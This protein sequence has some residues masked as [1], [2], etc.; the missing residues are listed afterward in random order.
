MLISIKQ[1]VDAFSVPP[2][3]IRVNNTAAVM[4]TATL[5]AFAQPGQALDI[6]VS[7]MGNSKS[8]RRG[9]L[10]VAIGNPLGFES[11]VT[12]GVVSALGRSIRSVSGR[13]IEDVT[14]G[15][16]VEVDDDPQPRPAVEPDADPVGDAD[17]LADLGVPAHHLLELCAHEGMMPADITAEISAAMGCADEIEELREA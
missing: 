13:T 17:L 7:S 5:P 12:A 14:D 3:A 11:T 16:E 1:P 8:L 4:V 6:T 10:V 2:T 15:D 9:Q